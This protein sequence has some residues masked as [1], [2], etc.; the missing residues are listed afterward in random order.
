MTILPIL[1]SVR[2]FKDMRRHWTQ[3]RTIHCHCHT[4]RPLGLMA[5]GAGLLLGLNLGGATALAQE[6]ISFEQIM[7]NPGDLEL[8][9]NYAM[10]QAD[11][12]YLLSA[13]ATIE[14]L[15]LKE[16]GWDR[17]RLF[18]AALLYRLGDYQAAE[19]ELALLSPDRLPEES[20]DELSRYSDKVQDK[21]Q[22]N[23]LSGQLGVGF[24]YDDNV[25]GY[26]DDGLIG[27][28][29]SE[30]DEGYYYGARM[31]FRHKVSRLNDTEVFFLATVDSKQYQD[32]SAFSQTVASLR[33]G[34]EGSRG[35]WDLSGS[36]LSRFV[37][38]DEGHYLTEY[39][40]GGSALKV[41][42]NK[43]KLGFKSH[44]LTQDFSNVSFNGIATLFEDVRRGY[45]TE[46]SGV[47]EHK[48]DA[49]NRATASLGV[50]K[51]TAKY[52]PYEYNGLRAKFSFK[53]DWKNGVYFDGDY[54][55]QWL[56][57]KEV[58]TLIITTGTDPRED[59]R[60]YLRAAVGVPLRAMFGS[61]KSYRDESKWK[62]EGSAFYDLRNSN[63]TPYEFENSG[64]TVKL[65][66]RFDR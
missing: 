60:H 48:F 55:Y 47:V 33:A 45:R 59:Q 61:D 9:Y 14:R 38:F 58:D 51:K 35:P 44:F 13:A 39:G 17:G 41:M 24:L 65:I 66:W 4:A 29:P 22:I 52:N 11:D 10:Q 3:Q 32:L 28:N 1:K 36:L 26:V 6:R 8:N 46:L 53:H 50:V 18:Y 34:V 19:R 42:N 27:G 21:N 12:G 30:G 5:A 25:T 57:Y 31:M 37:F 56:D 16:P 23:Y 40:V 54:S 15:L 62:I 49:R 64:A 7:A 20:Q 63:Y 2:L 43:T